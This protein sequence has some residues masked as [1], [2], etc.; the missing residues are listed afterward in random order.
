VLYFLRSFCNDAQG[1]HSTHLYYKTPFTTNKY[2][3]NGIEDITSLP[4]LATK[5][6]NAA[7][8]LLT[9]KAGGELRVPYIMV[10]PMMHNR[11]EYK[12]VFFNFCFMH[13]A[14]IQQ[15]HT[16]ETAFSF[17]NHSRLIS[18]ALGALRQL[19]AQR[20]ETITDFLVRVDVFETNEIE[21]FDGDNP[22]F[23]MRDFK[24]WRD[25]N[26]K[27]CR[28][29]LVVNEFESIE[30]NFPGKNYDN[31]KELIYRYWCAH[32]YRT[33]FHVVGIAK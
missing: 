28:Y 15:K 12:L 22:D 1:L 3:K 24:H 10:Q 18:F 11:K 27:Y 21:F 19:K 6:S 14:N 23:P 26:G 20:P 29:K 32:M 17:N 13:I 30:A 33:L 5:L 25:A 9:P 7:L 2:G 31:V 16:G 4:L 8:A